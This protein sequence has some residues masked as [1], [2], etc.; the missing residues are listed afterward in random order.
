[1]RDLIRQI[2]EKQ[3]VSVV[4]ER[5]E[6]FP[7]GLERGKKTDVLTGCPKSPGIDMVLRTM[8]PDCIAVDEITAEADARALLRAANCGVRLL[9]TAHGT[10]AADLRRRS[11]YRPLAESGVFQTLLILR[12]DKSFRAERAAL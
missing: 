6:L 8:G 11:V 4:D 7:E 1:M 2:G 9:A 12:Q 3:C 10:S 5:G